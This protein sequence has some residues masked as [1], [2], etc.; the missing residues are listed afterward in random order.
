ML[1]VVGRR[2][3]DPIGCRQSSSI[4][5]CSGHQRQFPTGPFVCVH[6][7]LH[8]GL[9]SVLKCHFNS[10]PLPTLAVVTLAH[11]SRKISN[12]ELQ[13]LYQDHKIPTDKQSILTFHVQT[14]AINTQNLSKNHLISRI[15]FKEP[16]P[17]IYPPPTHPPL[18]CTQ[19]RKMW[20]FGDHRTHLAAWFVCVLLLGKRHNKQCQVQTMIMTLFWQKMQSQR[21]LFWYNA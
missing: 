2:P 21:S 1:H 8:L 7:K 12:A 13:Q 15:S 18:E 5:G 3:Q 14:F 9:I 16:L 10:K 19:D 4:H 17:H 11:N 20:C 6:H